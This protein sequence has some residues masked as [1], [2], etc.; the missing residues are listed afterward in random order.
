MDPV[1]VPPLGTFVFSE[2]NADTVMPLLKPHGY[3]EIDGFLYLNDVLYKC[4]YM[5]TPFGL[6]SMGMFYVLDGEAIVVCDS[7]FAVFSFSSD[8]TRARRLVLA[9]SFS[10]NQPTQ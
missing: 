10:D 5:D 4:P 7:P 1:D 3:A 6:K 8:I 9:N 2:E